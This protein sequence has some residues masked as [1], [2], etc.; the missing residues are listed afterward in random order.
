[1]GELGSVEISWR[2]VYLFLFL[3]PALKRELNICFIVFLKMGV[4][5][6]REVYL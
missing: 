6:K 1:M 4:K 2:V 5:N 3:L